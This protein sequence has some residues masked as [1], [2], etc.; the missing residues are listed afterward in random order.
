MSR[1]RAIVRLSNSTRHCPQRHHSLFL[2]SATSVHR[3]FSSASFV[4]LLSTSSPPASP[5]LRCRRRTTT[6]LH[7][8]LSPRLIPHRHAQTHVDQLR[9]GNLFEHNNKVFRV[10]THEAHMRG[11]AHTTITLECRDEAGNKQ[12]LRLRPSD[13]VE[14]V[15]LDTEELTYLY[16]DDSTL[17]LMHPATFEPVE[18]PL[19]TLSAD[20]L[21]FLTDNTLVKCTKRGSDY[22][23]ITLPDKVSGRVVRAGGAKSGSMK[24]LNDMKG[25]VVELENGVEVLDCPNSVEV[26]DVIV[27]NTQTLRFMQKVE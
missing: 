8:P 26:G 1:H 19:A 15:Q 5:H 10:V 6:T 4:S 3:L 24:G 17:H 16:R 23:S 9:A 18:L 2:R 21:P 20:Q 12:S 11:R 22:L 14:L 27:V 13:K 7:L 25:R